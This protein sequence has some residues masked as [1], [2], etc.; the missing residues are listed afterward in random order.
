VFILICQGHAKKGVLA[1]SGRPEPEDE[2]NSVTTSHTSPRRNRTRR[3]G[4]FAALAGLLAVA[5]AWAPG[6]AAATSPASPADRAPVRTTPAPSTTLSPGD[7][8][9][10]GG[11]RCTLGFNVTDGEDVFILTAGHCTS[12]GSYWYADPQGTVPIGPTVLSSFP[13]NDFGLIRYENPGLTSPGEYTAASAYVG[14]QV[15]TVTPGT[16]T[17]SGTVT[18]LNATVNYGGGNIV[19]GLIR[20]N[21]CFE[22][23]SSGVPLLGA[24]GRALGIA[25]GGSGTCSSGGTSYFQPVTEALASADLTLY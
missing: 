1:R 2:E 21:V 12:A 23:S 4:L 22:G 24:G 6:A 10:S 18:G 14:E 17:H 7:P 15:Y 16:G 3:A 8:I 11:T 20:T 19:Y 25:S 5:T 13:G 9:Y